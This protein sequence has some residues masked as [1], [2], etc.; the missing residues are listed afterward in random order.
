MALAQHL[1]IMVKAPQLGAVKSRLGR[2]IGAAAALSFYRATTAALL[3]RL[4]GDPRWRCWLAVTP[5]RFA[6]GRA[7]WP[8]RLARLP[9]GRGDLGQRMARPLR[10]LPPGPVVIV[11]SDI[12]S[13]SAAH[14]ARAFAALGH[15]DLVFGPAE[16]GG[17]WLVGA[18]RRPPPPPDLFRAVRWSSAH[19]LADT[20]ANLGPRFRVALVDTLS[21]VD[22]AADYARW[23]QK[24]AGRAQA[25]LGKNPGGR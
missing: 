12:P 10:R 13:L 21:D 7:F 18:R 2:E 4:G 5:D 24:G 22:T 16:D 3:K 9:Q 15:H 11:G 17:Y 25:V 20:L 8:R 1:V 14:V 19:A 23:R 6:K